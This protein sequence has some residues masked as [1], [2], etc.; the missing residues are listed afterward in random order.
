L[1]T[2]N[3]EPHSDG[4][5]AEMIYS[6]LLWNATVKQADNAYKKLMNACIDLND[7][8]MNTPQETIEVIGVSYPR[9][10]DRSRRLRALLR[11]IYLREHDVKLDTLED[12]N[13]TEI[14][15]YFQTLEGV[16]HFVSA[17][18]LSLCFGISAF[19]IDDRTHG[20][21]INE[22]VLHED[23]HLDEAASWLSRQVKVKDVSRV[24][25]GLHAWIE[26]RPAP[27]KKTS[28]NTTKKKTS[29]KATKKKVAKKKITKKKTKKT[30][31]KSPAKK[32]AKKKVTKK[33]TTKKKTP[34][35]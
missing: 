32:I 13:K 25:G 19:P 20:A 4:P 31:K 30:T 33:K 11:A 6:Q 8:R 35:K 16:S 34:K 12:A 26:S 28:K 24:H 18:V 9:A 15:E 23:V 10:E 21:L 7:L 14:K 1:P 2:S 3:A 17:R 22:G 29:K 27:K 5:V